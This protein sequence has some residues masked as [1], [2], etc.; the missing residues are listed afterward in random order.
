[1]SRTNRWRVVPVACF[2]LF[3]CTFSATL[4]ESLSGQRSQLSSG[5]EFT[6]ED[7]LDVASARLLDLSA[8]GR[9]L[10]ITVASLRDR[11]GV[12]NYRYGDPTYVRPSVQELWVI[13]THSAES[14]QVFPGKRNVVRASWS[15]DG[16]QLAVMEARGAT[17]QA[18]V[19][20]RETGERHD[21][22]LPS[23]R[24]LAGQGAGGIEWTAD[25]GALLLPLR[26]EGWREGAQQEFARLTRGPVV[27]QSSD[28]PFL[29]WEAL[30][31]R[32]GIQSLVQY[33]MESGTNSEV[34]PVAQL[35]DH[36]LTADRTH[37]VYDEDITEET[38]YDVI[39]GRTSTVKV[40]SLDG[41]EPET[42]IETTEDVRATW[43]ADG[44]F[45]AYSKDGDVFLASIDD[46][47]PRRLTGEDEAQEE[48]EAAEH[49]AENEEEMPRYSVSSVA[50]GGVRVVASSKQGL[51]IIEADGGEPYLFLPEDE[52]DAHAPRYRVIAWSPAGDNLYMSYASRRDWERGLFRYDID[53]RRMVELVEDDR[54]YSNFQLSEDGGTFV[55]SAADGNNPYDLYTADSGFR[56]I[57]RLTNLNPDLER[58]QLSRTELLSYLDVDGDSLYG[59]VYYPTDYRE[60]TAYPAVFIV[61]EEFFDDRFN[62][63]ANIL[64][65]HG[66]LVV[67][68]S[69]DL[70]IGY[71]GEAWLKGVTAAANK[72]IEMGLVD[73]A[74]LGVMGTSYGGYATNLLITQTD[75]FKA[76]I[77]ISGKVDMVS[78]YTDSPR[79]GVRN[80]HAPEK[81]QD[82]IGATLWE[83]PQKYIAHS[84]IM[85][86]DRIETPLLLMTGEQ[87]HNV[88]ARTTMEMFY[89]LR[90]LGK[91][92][93]WVNYIDGGHGMPTMSVEM[94]KDYYSRIIDWYDVHLK[95]TDEQDSE[96]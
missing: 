1:M 21:V 22:L 5:T 72:L 44:R 54:L 68:P 18:W 26:P 19:W 74:R 8:D 71:P 41:G 61:Y 28:E 6:V 56:R 52:D 2:T 69:V 43:S 38:S 64:A 42:V 3:L 53:N 37:I 80:V 33:E 91:T 85:Y 24:E 49:G 27:V 70:E 78:F 40:I 15:P 58:K 32:S 47:E 86:A 46:P 31:R 63:T 16:R 57:R 94:V 20:D 35:A 14:T 76:A 4:P 12:D 73:P 77:N 39:F 9:W 36:R 30:R 81:S 55:F 51:W 45:F 59:V 11:I 84:A 83:Q 95:A 62:S 79:L 10:A 75:R 48:E 93:E 60:G 66:Y 17:F 25:G 23:G 89:A 34:I 88:P 7:A 87:D 90:R 50:P 96:G 29:A 65:N 82:R 92:V 67:N 13:D